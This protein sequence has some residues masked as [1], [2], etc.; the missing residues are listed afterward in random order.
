MSENTTPQPNASEQ[1]QQPTPNRPTWDIERTHPDKVEELRKGLRTVVD[2]EIGLDII[3]L[4]L[5]RNVRIDDDKNEAVLTM[6]LTTPFCPYGPALLEYARQK[7]EQI[8]GMPTA[9]E[10]GT[11]VWDMS[12]VEDG[13]LLKRWG[14]WG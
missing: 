8:L 3:T 14:L 5:V 12:M 10:M 4:G 6:I 1:A 9:V 2:P 11:E 7:A 13:E